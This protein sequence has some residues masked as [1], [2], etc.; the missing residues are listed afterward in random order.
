MGRTA[1]TT[2]GTKKHLTKAE[3]AKRQ[4]IENIIAEDLPS[5]PPADLS[6]SRQEIY[7]FI[8]NLLSDSGIVKKLDI[9]IIKQACITIDRLHTIDQLIDSEGLTNKTLLTAKNQLFQQFLKI[10]DLLMMS[11]Q[12]RAKLGAVSTRNKEKDPLI[13]LLEG[14]DN[15]Q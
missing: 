8:V 15:E 10:A 3:K 12:S 13:E 1:K 5:E 9:E 2:S 7:V 14:M 4:E 6:P 11:P